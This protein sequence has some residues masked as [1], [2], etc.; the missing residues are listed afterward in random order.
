MK[1]TYMEED[2]AKEGLGLSTEHRELLMSNHI[3]LVFHIA[4]SVSFQEPLL[5]T[6]QTNAW[7]VIELVRLCQ[8]MADVKVGEAGSVFCSPDL[9]RSTSRRFYP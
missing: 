5:E 8:A 2:M 1:V 4:A 6:M 9:M 7:P 3:S